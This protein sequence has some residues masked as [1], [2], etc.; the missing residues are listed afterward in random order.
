MPSGLD[1]HRLTF[2]SIRRQDEW[3]YGPD[4]GLYLG[5]GR[6]SLCLA[7]G[8]YDREAQLQEL[9]GRSAAATGTATPPVL[10]L[11]LRLVPWLAAEAGPN[12]KQPPWLNLAREAFAEGGDRMQIELTAGRNDLRLRGMLEA[13]YIRLLGAAWRAKQR[14]GSEGAPSN[15]A[16]PVLPQR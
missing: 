9:L 7:V 1:L 11:D 6:N 3:L 5:A 14:S 12:G 2:K 13:G 16:A 10:R 4:L 8:G 15:L